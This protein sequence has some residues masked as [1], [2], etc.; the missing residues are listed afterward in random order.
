[1]KQFGG[2]LNKQLMVYAKELDRFNRFDV[3]LSTDNSEVS[4][5]SAEQ[6]SGRKRRYQYLV[7]KG[8]SLVKHHDINNEVN[9]LYKFPQTK[10]K[11]GEV[12]RKGRRC[13]HND[14]KNILYFC[15]WSVDRNV[16]E[17]IFFL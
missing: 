13:N 5:I 8:A 1:M 14:C 6:E 7:K 16:M 9:P 15:V 4:I 11:N 3:I 10:G 2:I 17:W 12:Y